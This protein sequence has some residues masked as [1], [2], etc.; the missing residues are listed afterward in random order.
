M[1]EGLMHGY[2]K[3]TSANGLS[4]EGLWDFDKINE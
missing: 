1:F 4:F 3:F 2:G